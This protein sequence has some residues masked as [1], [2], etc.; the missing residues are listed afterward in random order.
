MTRQAGSEQLRRYRDG[1]PNL[2]LTDYLEFRWY[3]EGVLRES[4]RLGRLSGQDKIK[5]D[6]EGARQVDALL[7]SFL[8]A[9]APSINNPR[10]LAKRMAAKARL[11]R[12]EQPRQEQL[13]ENSNLTL[14]ATARPA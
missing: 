10:D 14:T 9:D 12:D 8:S 13:W 3:Y 5:F 1:L 11:L 7:E 2:V 6:R 4:A